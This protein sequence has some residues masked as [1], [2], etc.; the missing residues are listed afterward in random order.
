MKNILFLPIAMFAFGM[1]AYIVAGIIP[2]ISTSFHITEAQTA[3]MVTAFTLCYALS[4][5]ILATLLAGFP[6][7][8]GPCAVDAGVYCR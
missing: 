7:K 8:K 4:A 2:E 3:Q 6:T 5:P 1:D